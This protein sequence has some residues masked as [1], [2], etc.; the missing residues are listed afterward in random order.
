M[1]IGRTVP[2]AA[3]PLGWAD[4]WH[5]VGG[6]LGPAAAIRALEADLRSEFGVRDLFTVSS[7]TAA[8]TLALVALRSLSPRRDVVLPAFTCFSVPAAVIAAGLRPVLCDKIGR[9]SCRGGVG[10]WGGAGTWSRLH[11]VNVVLR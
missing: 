10:S 3:A 1:R 11:S 4:L 6:A 2:P 8:L 7:G 9:A 5:G